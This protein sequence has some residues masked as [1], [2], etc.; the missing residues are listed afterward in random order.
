MVPDRAVTRDNSSK[1]PEIGEFSLGVFFVDQH[2]TQITACGSALAELE[3][4]IS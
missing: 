1:V 2:A 4:I 3:M